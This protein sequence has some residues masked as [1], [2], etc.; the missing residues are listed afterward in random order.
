MSEC[1]I[2]KHN[3]NVE[4]P[5]TEHQGKVIDSQNLM[6]KIA[7]QKPY[8]GQTLPLETERI[9]SSIPKGSFT[10]THQNESNQNW[11]YP[12]HQQFYNAMKRKGFDA[13]EEDMPAVVGI[14]NAVN[15]QTW[16]EVMRYETRFHAS[17][18]TNIQLVRFQGKPRELS[19]KAQFMTSFLGYVA[20]FDRHDWVVDRCGTEVRYIVDFYRG[21]ISPNGKPVSFHLDARPALDSFGALKDRLK[22]IFY[23]I[24]NM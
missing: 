14:H 23:D 4:C 11:V 19:P 8:P 24:F 5:V 16:K 17:H 15:E 20:P 22:M 2:Q 3:S 7:E 9:V 21:Q 6:P 10:P 13:H 12:S 1:P 18:C